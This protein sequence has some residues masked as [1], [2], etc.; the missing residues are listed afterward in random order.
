MQR[1]RRCAVDQDIDQLAC[2]S[3]AREVDRGVSACAAANERGIGPGRALYEDL[4][5][6]PAVLNT[7]RGGKF[8]LEV[9]TIA[10]TVAAG[11]LNWHDVFLIPLVA[12]ITQQL[13]EVMGKQYV[14]TQREQARLRQSALVMQTVSVPLAEW[15][16]QW[17]ATG[18]SAYER[19]QLALRRIPTAVEHVEHAVAARTT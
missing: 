4:E 7:L 19:L 16:T 9:A 18:G 8:A 11:G 1:H 15:L 17:P 12:F 10:G 6:N 13:V 14:E 5:K 3:R 2:G